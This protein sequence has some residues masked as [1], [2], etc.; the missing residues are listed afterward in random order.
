MNKSISLD[1]IPKALSSIFRRYHVVL[2]AMT[3]VIGVGVEV[4]MLNNLISR[5]STPEEPTATTTVRFDQET[6]DRIN[7]LSTSDQN[8]STPLQLGEGRVNPFAE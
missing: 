8:E 1:A 2:F 5:S 6:I 4:I 7:R 3:V